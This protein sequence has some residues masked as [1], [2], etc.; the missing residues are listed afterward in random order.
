MN[1]RFL[2]ISIAIS[3]L[4]TA[5]VIHSTHGR[6]SRERYW[7]IEIIM[8][9]GFA[10]YW[11]FTI[12]ILSFFLHNFSHTTFF[13]LMHVLQTL[14]FVIGIIGSFIF[15]YKYWQLQILRLH[16]L[17]K[18][19]WYCL[20]DFIPFYNIYDFFVMNIKKRSIMLNEFDETIDYFSFFEKNKLL[21]NKKLITKDGVDFYVSGIKFEYKNFNGHVQYE[22]SKMSLEN[23]K[24]LEEYCMKNLQQT[25][26]APGYAGEYRISF[27]D[28]GNLFEQLKNDLHGIVID[29]GF[30]TINEVPFFVRENY[31]QYEIVYKT[32]DSSRI[33]NFSQVEELQDYS[34]QSL[35]KAQLLDLI[36]AP[37]SKLRGMSSS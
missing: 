14:L 18:S 9:G 33:K 13:Y 4:V 3:L 1:L 36:N 29:D 8:I 2:I 15:M 26:N 21:Q 17:N 37:R 20:L 7:K 27:L 16:D 25:E 22:V 12:F 34:C 6:I 19:G 35:T 30:I 31:L 24:T 10:S 5:I 28:E 23:D 32:K 11:F